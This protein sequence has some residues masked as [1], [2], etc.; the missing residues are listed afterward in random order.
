MSYMCKKKF[1]CL[2]A[3][4]VSG[5]GAMMSK[6]QQSL[7]EITQ[8]EKLGILDQADTMSPAE[9]ANFVNREQEKLK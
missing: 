7:E 2:I 3:K 8:L 9:A 1:A 6:I 5:I 4:D